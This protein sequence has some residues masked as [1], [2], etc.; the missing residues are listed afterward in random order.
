M[1]FRLM[2]I[3]KILFGFSVI[4]MQTLPSRKVQNVAVKW[5]YIRSNTI[6]VV[7]IVVVIYNSKR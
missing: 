4:D 3:N 2:Q 5:Y 6:A 7:A 1:S